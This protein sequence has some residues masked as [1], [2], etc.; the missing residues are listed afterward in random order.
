V[1]CTSSQT[2][3]LILSPHLYSPPSDSLKEI[4]PLTFCINL[5]FPSELQVPAHDDLL[6]LVL[7]E[8]QVTRVVEPKA[9]PMGGGG[10]TPLKYTIWAMLLEIKSIIH[11][12][13]MLIRSN[14]ECTPFCTSIVV[15]L[16]VIIMN[17]MKQNQITLR[18]VQAQASIH[19]YKD[20]YW[21][22]IER[23]I[24]Q[25]GIVVFILLECC[26]FSP[27]FKR[28]HSFIIIFSFPSMRHI[29][30]VPSNNIVYVLSKLTEQ[31]VTKR[32]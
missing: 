13:K 32:K 1:Y 30:S 16:S 10:K 19:V 29:T 21:H 11:R 2:T 27:K 8:Y 3:S 24:S 20:G 12:S 14:I 7:E 9:L 15:C 28:V 22:L 5:P 31:R 4:F 18:R 25:A 17:E 26:R 23:Q 6:H